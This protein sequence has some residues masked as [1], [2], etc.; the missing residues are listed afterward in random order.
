M[1]TTT[2]VLIVAAGVVAAWLICRFIIYGERGA[3]KLGRKAKCLFGN[4]SSGPIKVEVGGR[5]VQ[6]CLYCDRVVYE[7]PVT[8]DSI[9]RNK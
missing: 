9:R 8:K 5:N 2:L 7:Y 1:N 4:H 3:W 6:R